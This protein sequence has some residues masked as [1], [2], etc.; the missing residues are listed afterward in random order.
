MWK[1]AESKSPSGEDGKL[2]GEAEV[3]WYMGSNFPA[4]GIVTSPS[5]Q[6]LKKQGR[7]T[8]QTAA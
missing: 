1:L 7:A 6:H 8:A 2:I 4:D 3:A 5:L